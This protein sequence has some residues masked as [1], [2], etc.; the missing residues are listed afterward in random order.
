MKKNPADG[1]DEVLSFQPAN[2][3]ITD[4]GGKDESQFKRELV[5]GCIARGAYAERHEDRWGVGR[6]DLAIKFPGHP[7]LHAEGKL[8]PHQA[9]APT[10]RQWETGEKWRAAGDLCALIGW[11][12]RT[13]VMFIHDW[14]K[15]ASRRT[16]WPPGGSYMEHAET[17]EQWLCS[18]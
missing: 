13:G 2:R 8:V 9:F 4:S 7:H 16:S 1:V 14:A 12:P 17:L 18:R 6:L 10:R 11:D 3:T 15:E 5:R